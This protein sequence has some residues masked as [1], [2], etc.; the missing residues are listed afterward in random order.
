MSLSTVLFLFLAHLGVGRAIVG[1][2]VR[3]GTALRIQCRVVDVASGRV[4][5]ADDS[6]GAG[7]DDLFQLAGRLIPP[8]QTWLEIDLTNSTHGDRWLREI[9]TSSSDAYR[10]YLRG[11]AAMMA[12]RW[13]ESA[14]YDEQSLALDSTFVAARFDLTGCYWNLGDEARTKES[15][16]AAKRLRGRASPREALQLDMIDAV[17]AGN[18]EQLIRTASSL[19]ELYP[20]NR[21]FTYLVGR[22]YFTAGRW[23]DCIDVLAPLVRE[24]WTWAWTYVLTSQSYEKLGRLGEAR[25]ALELGMDVT[26]RNPEVA[27]V[28][29]Q[30]LSRTGDTSAARDV[31]LETTRSPELAETPEFEAQIRLELGKLY[32]TQGRLDSARVQYQRSIGVLPN[33]SAEAAGARA[34]LSAMARAR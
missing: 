22:G 24:R 17:I 11:H 31:L 19:R 16:A 23:N 26:R 20:E 4:L 29:A 30:L 15:L 28:L 7:T 10:L 13:R 14:G 18:S 6:D 34:R 3:S 9:T 21:F 1:S 33:G 32:E 8:L 12:S 2:I 27:F 5:H 25:R